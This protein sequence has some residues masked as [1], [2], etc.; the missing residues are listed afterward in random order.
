MNCFGITND[1]PELHYAKHLA[2]RGF[3]TLAPD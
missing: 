3:V 1:S 2:E